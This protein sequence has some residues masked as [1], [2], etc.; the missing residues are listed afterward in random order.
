[1]DGKILVIIVLIFVGFYFFNKYVL[2]KFKAPKLT[3]V[4]F[5]NGGIKSGKSL[6]SFF[7]CYR[8]F[9]RRHFAWK[10]LHN[11]FKDMEEPLL[12]SNI[13]LKVP[14]VQ[15]TYEMAMREERFNYG[16]VV[17]IDEASLFADSRLAVDDPKSNIALQKLVK[18]FG[19]ETHGGLMCFNSQSVD[20]MHVAFRRGLSQYFYVHHTAKWIPFFYVVYVRECIYSTDGSVQNNFNEDLEESLQ[21]IIIPKRYRKIYDR[22]AFSVETDDLPHNHKPKKA[23][24][25]KANMLVSLRAAFNTKYN[26]K[27]SKDEEKK[28]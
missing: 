3:A 20:D 11:F 9:R 16:S 21:K 1:M 28:H 14:Y 6:V 17:F 19:H 27:E 25:L 22:F 24:S 10:F 12:Y 18:L 5:V 15:L 23:K 7:F 26:N 4:T 8:E 2:S 13:P